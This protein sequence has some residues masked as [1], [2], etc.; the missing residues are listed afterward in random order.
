MHVLK[1]FSIENLMKKVCLK[2][3]TAMRK[4]YTGKE[5]RFSLDLDFSI[6]DKYLN[7][8]DVAFDFISKIVR[9]YQMDMNHVVMISLVV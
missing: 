6:D 1:E 3:G 4:Y 7:T 5:G 2:G 9:L 8:E